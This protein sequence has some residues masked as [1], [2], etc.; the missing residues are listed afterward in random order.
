MLPFILPRL[1]C[2]AHCY[3][4]LPYYCCFGCCC[5]V[6]LRIQRHVL[7]HVANGSKHTVISPPPQHSQS[8]SLFVLNLGKNGANSSTN[9][10]I[11]IIMM[12]VTILEWYWRAVTL[13]RF[14]L[15]S[16]GTCSEYLFIVMTVVA[17]LGKEKAL[18][19]K[20]SS[21]HLFPTLPMAK[22]EDDDDSNLMRNETE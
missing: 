18:V 1:A 8:P 14:I 17:R 4:Y 15:V 13:A 22:A 11:T 12:L 9:A 21:S 3:Q 2:S 6:S 10:A 20:P 7:T 19:E 5:C 16:V